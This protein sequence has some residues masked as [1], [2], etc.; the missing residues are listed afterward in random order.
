MSVLTDYSAYSGYVYHEPK[1]N[2]TST[3]EIKK[4]LTAVEIEKS[5]SLKT[6]GLPVISNGK[7]AHIDDSDNH[8]SIYGASGFKKSTCGFMP[9][10]NIT[11]LSNESMVIIDP[12]GELYSRTAKHVKDCGYNTI[13]LNFRD[14]N[15][16][17][18]N[19]LHYPAKLWKN[20]GNTDKAASVAN[21]FCSAIAQRQDD[22]RNI[23]PF[24]PE[25]AKA[26]I[27]GVLPMMFDSYKDI[28]SINLLTLADYFTERSAD[29]LK[30]FVFESKVNNAAMSNM[31]TVLSEPEKTRL[32]T[33]A[34]C[35]SFIQP[36]IQNDKLARML[37]HSTFELE[38][39][40]EP[41]TALY[42]I[43]DDTTT[44]CNPIVGVLISQLQTVL[45]DKAFHSENG[46]VENRVN[47]ILDEF[48]SFPI[49]GICEALATHRSRN[50]RYFLCIQSLSALSARYPHYESLLANCATALFFGSTEEKLL[51]MISDR[52][53]ETEKTSSG[54]PEPLISVPELMTLKKNWDSK[55]VLYMNLAESIRYCTTLPAIEQYEAFDCE[56]SV[57]PN[58]IHPPVNVYTFRDLLHDI[59][60]E[61]AKMP[62]AQPSKHSKTKLRTSKR[63]TSD[64]KSDIQK[65]LEAK[66]D[67]LF[68]PVSDEE[69]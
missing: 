9:L 64:F 5:K 32:S 33:L 57:L 16:D 46:K 23:D 1:T 21:D 36:F 28:D 26:F 52:C 66:F 13:V 55:E 42:I 18:Y 10:I 47:F 39:L 3:N 8:C 67:E 20:E 68:G 49:P 4:T 6:G 59:S 31:R 50:I 44:V 2:W 38:D 48:C 12:K 62:F 30:E 15:A 25:T 56:K 60:I 14:F 63:N 53:G 35:S 61:E 43:T 29:C 37:S 17:G 22:H 58:I 51:K 27:N 54:R 24:W 45:V 65:E 11:A 19:P 34:T 40:A 69:E 41:K 7:A